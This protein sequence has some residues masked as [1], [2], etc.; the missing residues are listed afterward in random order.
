M[1]I[2]V[3]APSGA[4]DTDQKALS[5]VANDLVRQ[6][7]ALIL[8]HYKSQRQMYDL[9]SAQYQKTTKVISEEITM[10]MSSNQGTEIVVLDVYP[11]NQE[12]DYDSPHLVVFYNR[13][14]V[15]AISM[16]SLKTKN[17]KPRY[18]KITK[19]PYAPV[20][21]AY[22]NLQAKPNPDE[23][24][25]YFILSGIDFS[26]KSIVFDESI[27]FTR[28]KTA[29]PAVS[30]KIPHSYASLQATGYNSFMP[31]ANWSKNKLY[32]PYG[33]LVFSE[34]GK[35]KIEPLPY[36]T[37]Y[38]S[39]IS[40]D[41]TYYMGYQMVTGYNYIDAEVS[42]SHGLYTDEGYAAR[43]EFYNQIYGMLLVADKFDTKSGYVGDYASG[44]TEETI[45][46]NLNI[47]YIFPSIQQKNGYDV[48]SVESFELNAKA[49]LYSYNN[50]RPDMAEVQFLDEYFYGTYYYTSPN[51]DFKRVFWNMIM[52]PYGIS[53]TEYYTM[54]SEL[55]YGSS[56]YQGKAILKSPYETIVDQ[57][58]HSYPTPG[59]ILVQGWIQASNG[60]FNLQGLI[61]YD[62]YFSEEGSTY[63]KKK[64]KLYCNGEDIAPALANALNVDPRDIHSVFMD[65]PLKYVKDLI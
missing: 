4:V 65:I 45:K 14:K 25:P 13:N 20:D 7:A 52:F 61:Y 22:I 2:N 64:I 6:Q 50:S 19:E 51:Q 21:E 54:R 3:H 29:A 32:T 59:D 63:T 16:S 40:S 41:G 60:E 43:Q 11:V 17:F 28:A 18:I 31:V 35:F 34:D 9:G 58:F 10:T 47:S 37:G 15:A 48:I 62:D 12:K 30:T 55:K 1:R 23:G 44:T 33:T 38:P 42:S 56:P 49:T 36:E 57:E 24:V 53:P 8:Q 46:E 39:A 5:Y 27:Y 26:K